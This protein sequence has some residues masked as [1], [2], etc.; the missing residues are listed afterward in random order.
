[1]PRPINRLSG[2]AVQGLTKQGHQADGGGLYLLVKPTVSKSRVLRFR[3][4]GRLREMGL[5]ST[6]VV[7]L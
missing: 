4:G 6:Q 5:G 1:M 2:R 3:R 7:S